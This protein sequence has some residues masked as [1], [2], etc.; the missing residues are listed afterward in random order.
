M[1]MVY[2]IGLTI[3]A[4]IWI[5][6]SFIFASAALRLSAWDRSWWKLSIHS[7]LLSL[8]LAFLVFMFWP[9][10]LLLGIVFRIRDFL[11]GKRRG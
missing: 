3:V 4:I 1:F 2:A 11:T 6:L 10:A 5:V 9:F 7:K 8:W